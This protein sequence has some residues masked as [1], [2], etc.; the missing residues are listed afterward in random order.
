MT[1][2][3]RIPYSQAE[4]QWLE[5]NHRMVISDYHRAFCAAFGRADVTAPHLHWLRK[6]RGWK[7]GRG[8][9]GTEYVKDGYLM[10][11][12][13]DGL[14]KHSR[15]R[16]VHL[17]NWEERHG[18]IPEG[19]TLKCRSNRANTDPSNWEL[20]PRG[21]L[22]RLNGRS[23]R[24]YDAAPAELKPTIMA[25]TRLEHGLSERRKQLNT[26]RRPGDS[27]GAARA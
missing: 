27:E 15:W 13:H 17:L 22:L 20:V 2:G 23:G 24:N 5:T 7:V 19:M 8:K 18:P 25:V 21:V 16:Y 4:M 11:K 26:S 3:L 10:R 14:P 9:I 12:I 1:R 6:R